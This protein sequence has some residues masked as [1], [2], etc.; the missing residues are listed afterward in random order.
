MQLTSDTISTTTTTTAPPASTTSTTISDGQGADL[1][2]LAEW[3]VY[4]SASADTN[5]LIFGDS[6]GSD[7]QDQDHD[8]NPENTW[9][10]G[11][12]GPARGMIMTGL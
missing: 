2:N 4:G 11:S 7:P 9:M 8:G 3:D 1:L 12:A 6:I 5:E 10:K